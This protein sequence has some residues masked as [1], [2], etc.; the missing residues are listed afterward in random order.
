MPARIPFTL[1]SMVLLPL[2]RSLPA[3]SV[4]SIVAT[5]ISM[6]GFDFGR[7]HLGRPDTAA[8]QLVALLQS[9]SI[10]APG[11]WALYLVV[12]AWNW[13]VGFVHHYLG[14]RQTPKP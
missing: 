12:N 2:L 5:L 1:N 9:F 13:S 3:A 6:T 7:L 8:D 14:S 4:A 10:A 11:F